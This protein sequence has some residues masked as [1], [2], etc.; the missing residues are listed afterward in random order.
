M[1]E[2]VSVSQAA[3]TYPLELL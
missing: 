2:K 1:G 3:D